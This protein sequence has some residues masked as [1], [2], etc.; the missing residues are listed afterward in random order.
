MTFQKL[1]IAAVVLA[2]AA[3]IVDSLFYGFLMKDFFTNEG[4]LDSPRMGWLITAYFLFA[5]PFVHLYVKGHE[6]GSKLTAGIQYG[7]IVAILVSA[8]MSV[9]ALALEETVHTN[10]LIANLI[11]NF[12]TLSLWGV[13]TAY[14]TGLPSMVTDRGPGKTTGGSATPPPPTG[15]GN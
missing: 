4:M 13:L 7:L 5:F 2:I 15:G 6:G 3:F 8:T 1:A 10:E 11:Y 9:F 12:V 14:L